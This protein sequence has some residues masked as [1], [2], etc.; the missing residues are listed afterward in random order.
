MADQSGHLGDLHTEEFEANNRRRVIVPGQLGK[1][2]YPGSR[3]PA[4]DALKAAQ[5]AGEILS[6]EERA[7]WE[8]IAKI[9]GKNQGEVWTRRPAWLDPPQSADPVDL[10]TDQI[11]ALPAATP[12]VTVLRLIV[13]RGGI[14]ILWRF[15]NDLETP[16]A[17]PQVT[18]RFVY[19]GKTIGF[20]IKWFT[21]LPLIEKVQYVDFHAK[22]GN[23]DCPCRFEAPMILKD[24]G[25]FELQASNADVIAHEA[26]ARMMGWQYIADAM[27]T[28]RTGFTDEYKI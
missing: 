4:T 24:G 13:P 10:Y 5:Q 26:R 1:T 25:T 15:G 16:S 20:P 3:T 12:N 2:G 28:Q 23:V 14:C 27:S 17:F 8:E 7:R 21:G 22:L 11:V 9:L 19:R 18:W 6:P